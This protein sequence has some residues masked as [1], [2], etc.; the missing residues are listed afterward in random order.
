MGISDSRLLDE[1]RTACLC[2][3]VIILS[4]AISTCEQKEIRGSKPWDEKRIACLC[5]D[6]II[7]SAAISSCEH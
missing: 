5:L 2:L 1:R 6:V 7:F 3:D 4:A